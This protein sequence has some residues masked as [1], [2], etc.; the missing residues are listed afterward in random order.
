MLAEG[1]FEVT[2]RPLE[3][4]TS[5]SEAVPMARLSIDKSFQG[6]LAATSQG[7]MLS[8]MGGGEGSAAYVA[9]EQ[10]S[11]ALGERS[12]TFVLQHFGVMHGG[13]NRLILEVAP[14]SGTAE[15]AGLSGQMTIKQ[16]DGKHC[17]A[18]EYTL[19]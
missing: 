2:L 9:L 7:E 10:V 19:E 15:L 3:P 12:G 1:E 17:Y 18:F 11:G 6:D 5:G 4:Y 16:D 8:V 13:E 14:D